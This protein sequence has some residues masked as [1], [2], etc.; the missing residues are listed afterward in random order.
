M[1]QDFARS[2][3]GYANSSQ[4]PRWVWFLTGFVSGFFVAFLIYLDEFVPGDPQASLTKNPPAVAIAEDQIEEM[5][6]DFYELFKKQNVPVE[7]FNAAGQK[8]K[9]EEAV[10]YLLQAGSFQNKVDAN[11]LRG[12][13][14]LL[15]LEAFSKE[16]EVKGKKWHRVLVGPMDS[17]L[18]LGRVQ[19]Q[20]ANAKIASMPVKVTP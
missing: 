4:I 11:R 10:K 5:E 12:E 9:V 20:L 17:T 18:Q 14:I 2:S 6:W 3:G 16:V 15:G 19:Q 1:T 13:L 8:V 7:E